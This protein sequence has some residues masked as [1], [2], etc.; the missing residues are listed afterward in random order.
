LKKIGTTVIF[1]LIFALLVATAVVV[2]IYIYAGKP[3]S[4]EPLKQV[5]IIEPGQ[6]F[7][8]LSQILHQKGVIH[9][10]AKFRFFSRINGYDKHIKAGEYILSPTMTPKTILEILVMGRV[11]LHRLTIPEGHNLRQVAQVVSQAGFGTQED[12]FNAAT[13]ADLVRSKGIDAQTFEG[14]LFPDTYYFT[15]DATAEKIISSM[16]KR[17]WSVFKPEWKNRAKTLGFTIHQVV[18]LASII[19]KEAGVA[20]ERP[21]ISS[22]FHNR[23]KRRI[24]LESD[25]T[26]IYGIEDFNG[27]ITRRDLAEDTPYN[28][29]RIK[30]LP[31]GPIANAGTK[32]IEAALY[33][34]ETQFLYF[35]SKKNN[36]HR[37]STNLK[38]HNRAVQKYQLNR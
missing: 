22:V 15:K 3:V 17:F 35:V 13:N 21:V 27:N 32:A 26:V 14:Y 2:D 38:D 25:P 10:P 34:A 8:S 11:R 6:K 1:I 9:H 20:I 23:L 4:A 37:F 12:F 36:T 5:I 7:K 30:G 16:V 31:P 19:E 24:R 18:T 29:Y 33:P 28:T